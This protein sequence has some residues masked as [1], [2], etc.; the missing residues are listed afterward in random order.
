MP[1]LADGP[2]V[3]V[4]GHDGDWRVRYWDGGAVGIGVRRT[5]RASS[6]AD[7]RRRASLISR[8]LAA[9]VTGTARTGDVTFGEVV[10][11]WIEAT[12]P[13]VRAGTLVA[14]R[15][16]CNRH[17]LPVLSAVPVGRLGPD[18]LV[19]VLDAAVARGVSRRTLDGV[20]RT[21]GALTN[22]ASGHGL[23]DPDVWGSAACRRAAMHRARAAVAPAGCRPVEREL[24]DLDDVERLARAVARVYEHGE[25]LVWVMAASGLRLGEALG[26]RHDDLDPQRCLIRVERQADRHR[27]WPATTFPKSSRPRTA[28]MWAWARPVIAAACDRTAA[29]AFVF[30]PDLDSRG[31]PQRWWTT[32]IS[33]RLTAARRQVGWAERGWVTHDLRHVHAS[34]SLAP[35]EAGGFG[36]SPAT[37]AA[38]LGH[39]SPRLTLDTYTGN[40]ASHDEVAAATQQR[41]A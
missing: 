22:W 29:G 40:T 23:L 24:P 20:A 28:Y 19:A 31:R 6:E 3:R 10:A 30:P 27:P 34:I 18:S 16:D 32:R 35:R 25:E 11:L 39:H 26:L 15:S 1:R 21:I 14:Y 33:E 8:R 37:V 4:N 9:G 12:R 17:L 38:G 41:P 2:A 13:R 7:A 36:L 5:E